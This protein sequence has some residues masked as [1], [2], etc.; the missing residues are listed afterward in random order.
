M[1]NRVPLQLLPRTGACLHIFD[2]MQPTLGHVA[3]TVVKDGVGFAIGLGSD[4][5]MQASS[6]DELLLAADQSRVD[7]RQAVQHYGLS[8]SLLLAVRQPASTITVVG[9]NCTSA[10]SHKL[11]RFGVGGVCMRHA[12]RQQLPGVGVFDRSGGLERYA[13]DA[14]EICW[15]QRW[16]ELQEQRGLLHS[17]ICKPISLLDSG[18]QRILC[19]AKIST[20]RSAC[21]V[22][23]P[24]LAG[25]EAELISWSPLNK[26]WRQ[27][28][29]QRLMSRVR[30]LTVLPCDTERRICLI[31]K[32]ANFE[33]Y[34]G[35]ISSADGL[36]FDSVVELLMPRMWRYNAWRT[37]R[38]RFREEIARMTHN[39]G[40]ARL[41]GSYVV[42]GGRFRP[43]ENV[44]KK[45]VGI[46]LAA[47]SRL[48][49]STPRYKAHD[50]ESG[51]VGADDP[52]ARGDLRVAIST[53]HNKH[54]VAQLVGER[55]VRSGWL[56]PRVI[57][58]GYHAGCVERRNVSGT[59]VPLGAC[60]FDGRL[61]LTHFRGRLWLH[62][63]A[64]LASR[65]QRFVQAA[66]SSDQGA[67]WSPFEL[68]SL[69]GYRPSHGELYF[70]AAQPNPVALE[71]MLAVFPLVHR[72]RACVCIAFS[73]DAIRWSSPKPLVGCEA[74][75]ERPLHH[76]A[77]GVLHTGG[78]VFFYVHEHVP[79]MREDAL[80][81]KMIR[82]RLRSSQPTPRIVRYAVPELRLL[83]WT[84]DALNSLRK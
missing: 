34:V 9:H 64:N 40:I 69:A 84:Q 25:V 62:V 18:Q 33:S 67:T 36:V 63:R 11:E 70:F 68:I 76:P 74:S 78:R 66:S 56:Y 75:G 81:P 41:N 22:G 55:G 53:R 60:E 20:A 82:D 23:E 51:I 4:D 14:R 13:C 26:T 44:P 8:R 19:E 48:T 42:V 17:S 52:N 30:Y 37:R 71:T 10:G 49:S 47:S 38:G 57:I 39:L 31:F 83:Q 6:C 59:G 5:A 73:H 58:D 77:A 21:A 1:I 3:A 45:E 35:S 29:V 2:P 7:L 32:D 28:S 54:G 65:G 79:E 12:N 24:L 72:A 16:N 61:S 27:Q 46:W 80:T 43:R 15:L 50:G